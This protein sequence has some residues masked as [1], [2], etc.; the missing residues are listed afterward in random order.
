MNGAWLKRKDPQLASSIEELGWVRDGIHDIESAAIQEILYIAVTSRSMASFIVSL[1][2]VVD[3]IDGDTEIEVIENLSYMANREPEA[4]LRIVG[5]P[6]MEAIEPPDVSAVASLS[7]LAAFA[8]DI[9]DVVMSHPALE[10][11]ISNELAPIVATLRGTSKTNPDLVDVLLDPERVSL[12]RRDI[13]L[14]LSGDIVLVI[15]RT[16][17]GAARS[18]DLLENAVR[19][20]EE[21]MGSPLP[22]KY[23]GLL[24]ENA[25]SGSSAGTNFGTH[26]A[27]L[28]KYD[29]DD[30]SSEAESAPS[31][32]AHEVSHY[33]WGGNQDWVDEGAANFMEAIIEESR[34][35]R[36]AGVTHSPCAHAGSIAELESLDI[37]KEDLAFGCNYSLGERLFF[38][39]YRA[40]GDEMFQEG[41][42][43]LYAASEVEDDKGRDTSVDIEN[44]RESFH[45]RARA[46]AAVVIDRW[47]DGTEPYDLSHIDTAPVDPSL[48]VIG[49]RI[50]MAYI[51]T[52]EE[53]PAVTSFSAQDVDGWVYLTAKYSYEVSGGPY[54]VPLEI[55]EYYEDGF[56][57]RR[58]SKSITAE[59]GF[60]GGTLWFSVGA[61][62]SQ[63]WAPGR[64]VVLV[65][66]GQRK[67]I[68]VMYYVT[69]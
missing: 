2:W 69:P 42:R 47:Y 11:G 41:F 28:P 7:K 23:V 54:E 46:D 15:I 10:D 55:V 66:S 65:Y 26:I 36:T 30:G 12:E 17:P 29:I 1:G 33:Y 40:L 39:M 60:I 5:M 52:I 63:K 25:V 27:I 4:A 20:A 19:R 13:T 59:D 38:D 48:P 43:D 35:G 31:T 51:V 44:I 53:G 68:E 21:Y 49:G 18:M 61:S 24:Y 3:G 62:P 67:V 6:F 45:T 56:E 22:T 37:S 9:F 57:F 8:P 58:R 16:R 14:P 34:T 32:I 50:D 64:Y